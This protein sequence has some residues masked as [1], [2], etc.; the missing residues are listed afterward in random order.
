MLS[1]INNNK[2]GEPILSI[3]KSDEK[4]LYV[5]FYNIQIRNIKNPST[6]F[7]IM[8]LHFAS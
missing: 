3:K 6:Y 4:E 7:E 8:Q 1:K 2:L 5:L